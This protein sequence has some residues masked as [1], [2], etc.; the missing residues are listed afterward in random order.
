MRRRRELF[1]ALAPRIFLR[2]VSVRSCKTSRGCDDATGLMRDA[3]DISIAA[4]RTGW[5]ARCETAPLLVS[6]R[7]ELPPSRASGAVQMLWTTLC[8]ACAGGKSL[9]RYM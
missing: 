5:P 9:A 2:V 4:R 7:L 8:K 3:V 6:E 1:I